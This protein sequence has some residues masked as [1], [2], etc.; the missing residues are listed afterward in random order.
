MDRDPDDATDAPAHTER[1]IGH[2]IYLG[3]THPAVTGRR[4]LLVQI[5]SELAEQFE[6]DA[7]TAEDI[8]YLSIARSILFL[9]EMAEQAGLEARDERVLTWIG[10]G[11]MEVLREAEGAH[12]PAND[13]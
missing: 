3:D 7:D 1:R 12:Q 10:A 11:L 6:L 8:I 2:S 4:N 13:H 5:A 9:L